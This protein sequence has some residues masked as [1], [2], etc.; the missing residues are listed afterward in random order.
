[1]SANTVVRTEIN[2]KIIEKLAFNPDL[3]SK[4]KCK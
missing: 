4:L 3:V 2:E 1:M